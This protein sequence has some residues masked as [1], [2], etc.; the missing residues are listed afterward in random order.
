[1]CT[2][3]QPTSSDVNLSQ[4]SQSLDRIVQLLENQALSGQRQPDND[5]QTNVAFKQFQKRL[6]KHISYG[7]YVSVHGLTA[8][9]T[10]I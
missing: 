4:I 2:A 5:S 7:V 9:H 10:T 3:G 8:I 6:V 1:M